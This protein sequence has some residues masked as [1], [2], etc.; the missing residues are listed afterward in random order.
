MSERASSAAA[1]RLTLLR[2]NYW[3]VSRFVFMF[4]RVMTRRYTHTLLKQS[5][6]PHK[7]CL[8]RA[9][10]W[11][12]VSPCRRVVAAAVARP[13]V[14]GEHAQAPEAADDA[15]RLEPTPP[16]KHAADQH[17]AAVRAM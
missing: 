5:K 12:S 14:P 9:E 17:V 16:W 6:A 1:Q 2:S 4:L 3:S 7:D 10:K 15:A 11:T 8:R 13:R